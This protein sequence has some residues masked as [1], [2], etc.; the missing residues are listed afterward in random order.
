M[1]DTK[2]EVPCH[3]PNW[4]VAVTTEEVA[5]AHPRAFEGRAGL[6]FRDYPHQCLP[7]S[8]VPDMGLPLCRHH[9]CTADL[10]KHTRELENTKFDKVATV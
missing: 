5:L 1:G 2:G 7:V 9:V 4:A 10:R 3:S 8:K 6:Q